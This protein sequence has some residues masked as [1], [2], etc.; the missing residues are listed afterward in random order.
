ML[1]YR[2]MLNRM[3]SMPAYLRRAFTTVVWVIAIPLAAWLWV[4]TLR[5]PIT[6]THTGA[7]TTDSPPVGGESLQLPLPAIR[8]LLVGDGD[9]P[10]EYAPVITA[11]GSP[12]LLEGGTRSNGARYLDPVR[13]DDERASG[14]GILF[15]CGEQP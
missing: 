14:E 11:D 9:C 10:T 6:A 4:D 3:L 13:A 7:P 8:L 12:L 15:V 2:S 5:L 1:V